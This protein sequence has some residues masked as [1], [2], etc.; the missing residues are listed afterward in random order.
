MPLKGFI[1]LHQLSQRLSEH[2]E[3]LDKLPEILYKPRKKCTYFTVVGYGHSLKLFTLASEIFKPS[4]VT[5]KPRNVVLVWKKL[6]F[7][8]LQ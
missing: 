3:A 4:R 1:L 2:A 8:S 6:H 7:F 5:S